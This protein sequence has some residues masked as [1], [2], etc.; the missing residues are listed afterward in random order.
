MRRRRRGVWARPRPRGD[1]PANADRASLARSQMAVFD[2]Q[3]PP[4]RE[5][6]AN[7]LFG[8]AVDIVREV[9][10]R[11]P[12]DA[13]RAACKARGIYPCDLGTDG[14][15]IETVRAIDAAEARA[16]KAAAG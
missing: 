13:V 6:F 11:G 8:V 10:A 2:R 15:V 1:D 16:L 4:V 14:V 7:S 9:E 5:A 12:N 3:S